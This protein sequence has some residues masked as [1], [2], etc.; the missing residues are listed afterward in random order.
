[1]KQHMKSLTKNYLLR[2]TTHTCQLN[3]QHRHADHELVWQQMEVTYVL[4]H[5]K[6][7][8]F[9]LVDDIHPQLA[10]LLLSKYVKNEYYFLNEDDR[11]QSLVVRIIK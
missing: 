10:D 1:M 5:C 6:N 9:L 7:L 2:E 4:D 11:K 8:K 3:R